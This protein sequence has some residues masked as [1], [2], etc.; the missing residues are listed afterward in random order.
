MLSLRAALYNLTGNETSPKV[1]CPFQTVDAI[2]DPQ[3][4]LYPKHSA[5]ILSR[6]APVAPPTTQPPPCTPPTPRPPSR[7]HR[8]RSISNLKQSPP[9][10]ERFAGIHRFLW[11]R[12]IVRL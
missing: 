11:S 7:D 3:V 10:E 8:E 5:T 9:S 4:L 6:I 1:R 2:V 12:L